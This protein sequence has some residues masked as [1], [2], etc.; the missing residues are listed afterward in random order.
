MEKIIPCLWFESEAED[1]VGQ[2]T[3]VFKDSRV[4]GLTHYGEA[5]PGEA[6]TVLTVS[7]ELL[8]REYVAL[9][10]GTDYPFT[11]AV[12]FQVSCA[13]QDEVDHYWEQLGD[14]G[15]EGACGWVRDRWGLWW[16]IVPTALPALLGDPDTERAHRAMSAM[17]SMKKLDIAALRRA[18]DGG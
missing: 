16:Q 12:S 2:Y 5:G 1:A 14:G 10:G 8:G 6:G 15:E 9:N 7:F 13:D 11:E 4:L 3:S 18:A 17:L